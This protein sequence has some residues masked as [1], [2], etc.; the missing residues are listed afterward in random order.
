MFSYAYA[1]LLAVTFLSVAA[2]GADSFKV[3]FNLANLDGKK[4]SKGSFVMQVH[5]DWAPLASARMTEMLEANFFKGIR[6]FRVIDGFM[7]QFGIHGNPTRASEWREKRMTDDP[8]KESNKRGYISFATSGKD[9]RTTRKNVTSC[10]FCMLVT[11][12]VVGLLLLVPSKLCC[13]VFSVCLNNDV[14]MFINFGNNANLDGMGFAPF[15]QVID[16]MDVVD[17]IYKIGEK[18]Q[19]GRIQSEGNK[20]LKQSFPQLTYFESFEIIDGK[21]L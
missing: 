16:G 1:C 17:R 11:V 19:Q 8:V 13:F 14:E 15:A 6:F 7:A 9:S 4:G 20:Y 18:P 10:I 12:S 3:R 21:E 2:Q 5:P